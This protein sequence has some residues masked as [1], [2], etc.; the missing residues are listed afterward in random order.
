MHRFL[1]VK[2]LKNYFSKSQRNSSIYNCCKQLSLNNKMKSVHFLKKSLYCF[3]S[4]NEKKTESFA[5]FEKVASDVTLDD[6]SVFTDKEQRLSFKLL[7]AKLIEEI[8]DIYRAENTKENPLDVN[9]LSLVFYFLCSYKENIQ[10][11]EIFLEILNKILQKSSEIS[12]V[13]LLNFLWSL[14]V[15]RYEFQLK[16]QES[17]KTKLNKILIAKMD[18]FN[19]QQ[20]S[21]VS[22]ALFQ[23]YCEPE[24]K[25]NLYKLLEKTSEILLQNENFITK[26]DIINFLMILVSSGFTKKTLLEKFSEIL[27]KTADKLEE[28][29]IEKVISLMSELKYDNKQLYIELVQKFNCLNDLKP[30]LAS[31]IIFSLANVIPEEKFLLK[32][33]LKTVHT[34]WNYLNITNYV[35]L[36]LALS[37]FKINENDHMKTLKIL[38]MI[39]QE[40]KIFKFSDLEG[41]EIINIMIAMSI[42]KINDK[43]FMNL[44]IKELQPKLENLPLVDLVNLA[45]CFVIYVRLFEDFFLL[46]HSKCCDHFK[47]FTKIE[48]SLLKKTFQRVK[49]LIP[50][51]PFIDPTLY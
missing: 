12:T 18:N 44:L 14:G 17:D 23:I 21:S 51:S 7:N 20:I 50:N 49:V 6:E 46:I 31:N 19:V 13:Y 4:N 8:Y 22:F 24:D 5:E 38:K 42:I 2:N 29:E 11:N 28:G 34:Q 33:L 32:D 9:N 15:Y 35:N 43:D 26:I 48:I 3:S 10:D 25:Q 30:D 1:F 47:E 39:P 27:Q 41:Y 36:W 40:S 37:K 16:L 45:R